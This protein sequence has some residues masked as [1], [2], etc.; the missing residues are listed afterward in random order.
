MHQPQ[1]P[2]FRP[3]SFGAFYQVI[4][5]DPSGGPPAMGPPSA[6]QQPTSREAIASNAQAAL[7]PG[8]IGYP[9]YAPV[10]P[11]GYGYCAADFMGALP[12]QQPVQPVQAIYY[13]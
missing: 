4:A 1:H 10:I 6:G 13:G 11:A 9:M 8:Y 7:P 3:Q 12:A 2:T 5:V